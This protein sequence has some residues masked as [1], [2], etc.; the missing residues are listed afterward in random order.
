M[1]IELVKGLAIVF[2]SVHD[3]VCANLRLVY[4]T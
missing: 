4:N 2:A 3:L 1:S